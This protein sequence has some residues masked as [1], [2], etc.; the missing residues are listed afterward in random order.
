VPDDFV[1]L[2]TEL[3]DDLL[4]QGDT[5]RPATAAVAAAVAAAWQGL[6][7]SPT[8]KLQGALAAPVAATG[9]NS[10]NLGFTAAPVAG[11]P[12]SAAQTPSSFAEEASAAAAA[13][14]WEGSCASGMQHH[15]AASASH[16]AKITALMAEW[17][18]TDRATAEAF[19][20]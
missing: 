14:G 10:V 3:L 11:Q 6:A 13:V 1:S 2:Q 18:F 16:D 7:Q 9:S 19:Y 12:V 4:L 5:S 15:G 20:K 17:G 8:G